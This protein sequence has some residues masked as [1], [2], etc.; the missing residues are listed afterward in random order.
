MIRGSDS[1]V[2]LSIVVHVP[3]HRYSIA[4]VR[5]ESP[6]LAGMLSVSPRPLAVTLPATMVE[7]ST[8]ARI[9]TPSAG[10]RPLSVTV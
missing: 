6:S 3:F 10:R 9:S 5:S 4:T 1:W 7:P 8:D 2:R